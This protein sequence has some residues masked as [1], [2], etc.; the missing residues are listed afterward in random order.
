MFKFDNPY[1]HRVD[2][3]YNYSFL[4]NKF[5]NDNNCKSESACFYKHIK[6]ELNYKDNLSAF[7][8]EDYTFWSLWLNYGEKIFTSSKEEILENVNIERVSRGMFNLPD[9][10]FFIALNQ[11][12]LYINSEKE[13]LIEGVYVHSENEENLSINLHFVGNFE[14]VFLKHP[15]KIVFDEDIVSNWNCF[16]TIPIDKEY[17]LVNDIIEDEV[18]KFKSYLIDYS[19][20]N[21][22]LFLEILSEFKDFVGNTIRPVISSLLMISEQ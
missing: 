6:R 11:L 17:V 15:D 9:G 14:S 16:L 7:L 13:N 2:R 18:N 3:K 20:K 19:S 4:K 5:A 10:V 22:I 21:D 1:P 12:G 8:A